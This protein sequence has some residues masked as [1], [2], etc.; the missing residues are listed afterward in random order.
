MNYSLREQ[1]TSGHDY[2]DI[3]PAADHLQGHQRLLQADRLTVLRYL[4]NHDE[5]HPGCSLTPL[6][7]FDD[8]SDCAWI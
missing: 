7:V 4:Q 3:D 8:L 1:R 6:W 2:R 5:L